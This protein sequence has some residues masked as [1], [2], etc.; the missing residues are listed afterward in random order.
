MNDRELIEWAAGA[1]PGDS[2]PEGHNSFVDFLAFLLGA[3]CR[4]IL[5]QERK[6]H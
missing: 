1:K 6:V 4:W 3:I 2:L 5:A